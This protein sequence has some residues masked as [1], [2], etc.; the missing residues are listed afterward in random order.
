[1]R[2]PLCLLVSLFLSSVVA[3]SF[4]TQTLAAE[5]NNVRLHRREGFYTD[6]SVAVRVRLV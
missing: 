4:A 1:M 3:S 2:L 6:T 5:L